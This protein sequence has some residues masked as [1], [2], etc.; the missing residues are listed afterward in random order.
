MD[1]AFITTRPVMYDAMS[2][3]TMAS[4]EALKSRCGSVTI[5]AFAYDR[6]PVEGIKIRLLGGKNSHSIA[7]NL[8]ALLWTHS[9]SRELS[10]Y[11][12]LIVVNPDIGSMPAVHLAKRHNPS[13]KIIWTFHGLTPPEYLT[14]LKDRI[15]TRIREPAYIISMKKSDLVQVFSNFIKQELVKRGVL[16]EKIKVM[17]F[18]VNLAWQSSGDVKRIRERYGITE[19]FVVLYVGRLV[20]FKHVDELIT[21][22]SRLPENVCLLVVGGGPERPALEAQAKSLGVEDRVKFAGRVPDEELPDYYATCDVWATA[23]RHEGFCVPIVE[24]MAAGR[25]VVVPD[26]AA[27]PETTGEGGL[28][29]NKGDIENLTRKL[30]DLIKDKKTY[31]SL[32]NKSKARASNFE[33]QKV[34]KIYI[35][36]I[37]NI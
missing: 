18:G 10:R 9:I 35:N 4:A 5:Y 16:P 25:P 17:P 30:E 1:V 12:A 27:M 8:R 28:V 31:N 11:D 21:A 2:N 19:K 29:Y 37:I 23:S 14:D 34:L 33:I 3:F 26:V 36:E 6:P 15:L 22:I 20:R 13:L 24:A 32:L 7:S